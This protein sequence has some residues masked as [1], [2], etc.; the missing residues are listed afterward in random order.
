MTDSKENL[1]NEIL[2]VE[3]LLGYYVALEIEKLSGY[4]TEFFFLI[5]NWYVVIQVLLKSNLLL[6]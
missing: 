5:K 4:H 2:G 3:G 1:K 6:V